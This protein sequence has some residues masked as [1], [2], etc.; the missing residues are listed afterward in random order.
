[1]ED[2][3]LGTMSGWAAVLKSLEHKM[4][5]WRG[6]KAKVSLTRGSSTEKVNVRLGDGGRAVASREHALERLRF[7]TGLS[8]EETNALVK[9]LDDKA[10]ELEDSR[11]VVSTVLF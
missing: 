11:R 7:K 4:G 2:V 5:M 1:M 10:Q 3:K 9:W 6:Y 8:E